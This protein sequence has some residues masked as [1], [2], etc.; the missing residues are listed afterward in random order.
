MILSSLPKLCGTDGC[1]LFSGHSGEHTSYPTSAWSFMQKKDKNKLDKAGFAT[2][3]GG[4]K[5]AYQNHVVRS[6]RV[7]IPYERLS[8][9]PF[10]EYKDGYV[11]RLY[12]EQYFASPGVTKQS[13][14]T[15]KDSWIVVGQNAFVL[16]RT[17]RGFESLP[18]LETW[19]VCAL[20]KDGLPSKKRGRGILDLGHYVLRIPKSDGKEKRIEGSPQGMF[21]PE[22]ADQETNYL[23]KCVL[24]W[25][26]TQTVGSPYV[27]TQAKHLQAILHQ[28]NLLDVSNYEY[29][30]VIRHGLSACPLCLRFIRYQELHASATYEDDLSFGNAA[31]QVE[32]AIRSTIVNLFHIEPL[33][34]DQITHIPSNVA[35]GHHSCN[36]RLGQRR[37]RSLA[38]LIELDLKV[39]IITPE[40]I[41]TFGWISKDDEIIRSTL[42]SVWIRISE[43]KAEDAPPQQ[44]DLLVGN[45]PFVV[46]PVSGAGEMLTL[47]EDENIEDEED[48][49]DEEL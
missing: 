41:E 5:G 30:G 42:G 22:Y 15:G 7:I 29:K 38:E 12:P 47:I 43:N 35:W 34:Y 19:N 13:F 26:I 2:P 4:A 28:E 10:Q 18:P 21:A 3:R 45:P 16:Y 6:N 11:I 46:D 23:C 49:Y 9:V 24:A 8:I 39:G 31:G 33:V 37:C 14:I 32:G 44:A 25:L 36:T 40:G 27:T 17:H 1:R 20:E 48:E